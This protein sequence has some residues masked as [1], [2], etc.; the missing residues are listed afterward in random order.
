[1]DINK[2]YALIQIHIERILVESN[3]IFNGQLKDGDINDA[4]EICSFY[5]YDNN[6]KRRFLLFEIKIRTFLN[7]NDE[8][9][10]LDIFDSLDSM[11]STKIINA[12]QFNEK[13]NEIISI[14]FINEYKLKFFN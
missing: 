5:I 7:D 11:I 3:M 8:Y 2:I 1:M 9:Y 14:N 10:C 4:N 12:E 6:L 13:L